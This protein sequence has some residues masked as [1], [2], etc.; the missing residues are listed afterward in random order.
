MLAAAAARAG[1][2]AEGRVHGLDLQQLRVEACQ[3]EALATEAGR[4]RAMLLSDAVLTADLQAFAAAQLHGCA[5]HCVGGG[6]ALQA[7]LSAVE[8]SILR[9]LGAGVGGGGEFGGG[10]G[11]GGCGLGG[12]V[13][14]SGGAGSG[15][16]PPG[17]FG[18]GGG[19]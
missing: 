17:L 5:A 11:G 6:A 1:G 19:R 13:T 2:S 12:A 4:K 7:A 18:F 3:P 14:G 10:G 15:G 9:Q 16:V 8:P